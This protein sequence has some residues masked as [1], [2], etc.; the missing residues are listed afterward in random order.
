MTNNDD[1][2]EEVVKK[3]KLPKYTIY[4][5]DLEQKNIVKILECIIYLFN[6]KILLFL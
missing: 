5:T 1:D 3:I 4:F 2:D 6:L